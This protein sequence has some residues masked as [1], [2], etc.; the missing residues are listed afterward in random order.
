MDDVRISNRLKIPASELTFRASRSGGPGGQHANTSATRIEL[1]WNPLT[2][3][4]LGEH[5]REMVLERLANRLD[6]DGNLRLVSDTHRSQHR[7]RQEVVTRFADLLTSALRPKKKRKKTRPSRA[8]K[9]R[10]LRKKKHRG[11]I[12]KLRGRVRRDEE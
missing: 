10:R 11:R 1:V 8:S 5:R 6:G 12:K 2:S 3:S 7:N 4:V 9:E